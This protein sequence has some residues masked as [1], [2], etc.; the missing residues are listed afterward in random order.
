MRQK[1]SSFLVEVAA[2]RFHFSVPRIAFVGETTR[3][4]W[5]HPR[6]LTTG[7]PFARAGI[8]AR[9]FTF[10]LSVALELKKA[11]PLEYPLPV[12]RH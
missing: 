2:D 8:V 5:G 10:A 1:V 4:S 9:L 12:P 7:K 6:P 11:P 3:R